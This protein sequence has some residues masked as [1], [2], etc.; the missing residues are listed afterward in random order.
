MRT[1]RRIKAKIASLKRGLPGLA[2]RMMI[3][4]T[5]LSAREISWLDTH[6]KTIASASES[7]AHMTKTAAEI[8]NVSVF[9][10]TMILRL[11][12]D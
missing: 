6:V 8:T 5:I 7:G 12:N 1:N 10:T 4:V 3:A 11:A 9:A 2:L